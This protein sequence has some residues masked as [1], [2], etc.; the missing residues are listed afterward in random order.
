MDPNAIPS[1]PDAS[2]FKGIFI[3]VILCL[4]GTQDEFYATL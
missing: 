4:S 1:G 3:Y 2:L